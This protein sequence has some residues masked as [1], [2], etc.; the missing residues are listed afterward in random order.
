M[1]QPSYGRCTALGLALL[2]PAAR[3]A[4][5]EEVLVTITEVMVGV[6][7]GFVVTVILGVY[8]GKSRDGVR[9]RS[10]PLA[11]QGEAGGG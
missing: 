4:T 7:L 3:A 10:D 6:F 2:S 9:R 8:F 11:G 5:Q 1:S